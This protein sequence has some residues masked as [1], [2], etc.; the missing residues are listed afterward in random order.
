M[1]RSEIE[2]TVIQILANR[3]DMAMEEINVDSNLALDLSMTSFDAVEIVFEVEDT[4][5]VEISDE[6]LA[7]VRFVRDMI[8]LVMTEK[9]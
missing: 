9:E 6:K 5:D 1:D 8:D 4:F 2:S 3:L 7:D